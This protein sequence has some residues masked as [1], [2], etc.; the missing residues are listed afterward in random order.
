MVCE[1]PEYHNL[2]ITE[3]VVVQLLVSSS[4]KLSEPHQF[5]YKALQLKSGEI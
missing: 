1:V 2:D 4:D 3:D 5:I